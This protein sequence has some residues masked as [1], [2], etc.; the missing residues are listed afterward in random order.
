MQRLAR[1][2][3]ARAVAAYIRV[4]NRA[5]LFTI[6]FKTLSDVQMA[7]TLIVEHSV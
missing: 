7:D 5:G 2:L 1:L 6:W 4:V 3:A